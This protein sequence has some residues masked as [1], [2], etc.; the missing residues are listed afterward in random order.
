MY[1]GNISADCSRAGLAA[2][3]SEKG[4]AVVGRL[5]ASQATVFAKASIDPIGRQAAREGAKE[6][7]IGSYVGFCS[8]QRPHAATCACSTTTEK[9]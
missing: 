3:G 5:V 8:S 2:L 4:M 1:H 7:V 9:A 6:I